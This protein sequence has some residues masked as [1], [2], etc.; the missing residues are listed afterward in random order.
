MAERKI[1]EIICRTTSSGHIELT[2]YHL[3]NEQKDGVLFY[4][5]QVDMIIKLLEA[6][7]ADLEN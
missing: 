5:E 7:S 1:N 4:P 3:I 2:Q 6:A